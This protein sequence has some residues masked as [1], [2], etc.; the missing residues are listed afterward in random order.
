MCIMCF[1]LSLC[2]CCCCRLMLNFDPRCAHA[3]A[4]DPLLAYA[5]PCCSPGCARDTVSVQPLWC[6]HSRRCLGVS[7]LALLA[8]V[9]CVLLSVL[10]GTC[11]FQASSTCRRRAMCSSCR[12][13]AL[14]RK[15][16]LLRRAPTI[17][18]LDHGTRRV[19]RVMS[20]PH[21]TRLDRL[22]PQAVPTSALCTTAPVPSLALRLRITPA[23]SHA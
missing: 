2:S 8:V 17:R 20:G 1:V 16:P 4:N 9:R 19:R 10:P 3:T 15:L 6:R 22:P 5:T 18:W 23:R 11:A 7:L 13:R 14:C 21:H 12:P